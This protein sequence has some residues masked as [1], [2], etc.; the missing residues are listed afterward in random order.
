MAG[1]SPVTD[2][3]RAETP[4][5]KRKEEMKMTIREMINELE[6]MAQEHGDDMRV[7]IYD[8]YAANEGWDLEEEDLY[9]DAE[10]AYDAEMG[11]ILVR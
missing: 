11:M 8:D 7:C 2:E 5:T 3:A 9:L 6:A 10:A 4:K 1:K